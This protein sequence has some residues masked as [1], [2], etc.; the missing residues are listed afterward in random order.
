MRPHPLLERRGDDLYMD[1]PVTVGEAML[2][3]SIEV[4]TPDGTVRVKVP[5]QQPGRAASCG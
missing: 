5:A 3:A 2:G 4:P 1:M